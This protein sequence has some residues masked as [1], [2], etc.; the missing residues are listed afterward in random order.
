MVGQAAVAIPPTEPVSTEQQQ[1]TEV[2]AANSSHAINGFHP[3]LTSAAAQAAMEIQQKYDEERLKR[4]RPDGDGQ[5]IDLAFSEQFKHY[6]ED[7]F[8]DERS[9]EQTIRDGEHVKYL[10]LGA[11]CGGL[12]YA[13]KL[14]KAGVP[15]SEIRIVDSAGGFGGTWYFNRYPV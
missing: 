13:A 7:P 10:I 14:I 2:N 9:E 3:D 8:L 5:Y 6:R 12:V 1:K 15:A 11:G 4:T